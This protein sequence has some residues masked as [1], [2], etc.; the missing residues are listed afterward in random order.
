[1]E[2]MKTIGRRIFRRRQLMIA[3]LSMSVP[4]SLRVYL[5]LPMQRHKESYS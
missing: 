5:D 2:T 4:H 3:L 1:M